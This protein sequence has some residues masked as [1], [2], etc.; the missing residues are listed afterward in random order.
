MKTITTSLLAI[1]ILLLVSCNCNNQKC[2]KQEITN[3]KYSEFSIVDLNKG[4]NN[5]EYTIH[6]VVQAYIN[7]IEEIDQNGPKI[8]SVIIL[9]PDALAIADELDKELKAGKRRSLMHGVPVLLKDNIDTHDKMPTTAGSR[10]LIN[11]YPLQDSWVAAKLREA[12]AVIIGKANLSE[13]ANFRGQLSISGWS[14]VGGQTKNPYVL[15]RNP[16]GSSA[17]SGASVSANLCMIAIGTETNGSILCP[18]QANG[19]VGIKPIVGLISRTGIIPISF[20][21]DTPGPMA[22]SVADAAACLSIMVG[23]DKTDSKTLKNNT[24][25]NIDYTQF[26]DK[27]GLKGKK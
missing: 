18:S 5:N 6:E 13:W 2:E 14:G 1:G 9:N 12:G 7:R 22:R 8:N 4:Y 26:L 23:I 19:I 21:Q 10:A 20:T 27:D 11:S 3:F 17:G 16:C 15:D 25:P 24:E